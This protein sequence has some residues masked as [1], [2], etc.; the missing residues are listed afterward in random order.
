MA[1][2]HPIDI[3]RNAPVIA[4]HTVTIAATLATTWALHC[5][6]NEWTN[7]N[8]DI[9]EAR[10]HGPFAAGSSFDWSSHDFPVTSTI[11]AV[12]SQHRILWGG[13]ASGITGIHEWL[14]EETTGGVTVTTTESFAGEPVNADVEAMQAML[15]GSL[16][17]WL[18]HLKRAAEN[19]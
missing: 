15:D 13:P 6:V 7:W 2:T 16:Q 17:S 3:D 9:T 8:P 19:A 4:H 11:Y 5:N 12:D 10:L 14:F 18:S 1:M